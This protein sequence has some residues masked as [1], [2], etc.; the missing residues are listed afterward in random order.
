MNTKREEYCPKCN[1]K[2]LFKCLKKRKCL[3]CGE[4]FESKVTY[5]GLFLHSLRIL[6]VFDKRVLITTLSY[7]AL[8]IIGFQNLCTT[9]LILILFIIFNLTLFIIRIKFKIPKDKKK[10][11]KMIKNI[12][13]YYAK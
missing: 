7:S 4:E 12:N 3:D 10:I 9:I 13:T 1:S 6:S 8:I 11:Y 5:K 2:R